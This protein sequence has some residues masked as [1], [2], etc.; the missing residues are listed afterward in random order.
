MTPTVLI[1]GGNGRFGRHATQ[2]FSEAGWIVRQF[3]RR[4]D[5]L[6]DAAWGAQVIVNAWNAP[7]ADWAETLPRTTQQV[8]E[9]AEATG[10][11]VIIPGNVYV[12]GSEGSGEL[13]ANTPHLASNPLGRLRTEMEAA[14]RRANVRTII[15]RGGDFLDDVASGNWFDMVIAKPVARG[16]ISYPGPLD[17]PHAWAFLPDMA[18]AAVQLAEM[19]DQL[20]R[21]EDIPFPGYTL[22]GAELAQA[23]AG[24]VGHPVQA[25]TMSW[26]PLH[27]ARP[28]WKMARHLVEMRYLWS[29][30]H[31]LNGARFRA[32][33]PRFQDTPVEQAVASALEFQINPDEAVA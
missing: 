6:W 24:A 33:L 15:L 18:R 16:K 14:Y 29:K 25:H 28:F 21:F 7:Y 10:A 12:F 19:R 27:L 22:T 17:R 3:D 5:N 20:S 1:L 13:S 9:V 30:P 8:I 11:T 4:I 32:L 26:A 2:A 23:V 31:H